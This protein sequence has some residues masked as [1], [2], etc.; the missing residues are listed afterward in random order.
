MERGVSS[1][2]VREFTVQIPNDSIELPMAVT[3]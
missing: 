2:V 1:V 3:A